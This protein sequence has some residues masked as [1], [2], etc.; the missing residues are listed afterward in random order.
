MHKFPVAERVLGF[1]EN[2]KKSK[3]F[4]VSRC[5]LGLCSC[6]FWT[7]SRLAPQGYLHPWA[8]P[9]LGFKIVRTHLSFPRCSPT[10]TLLLCSGVFVVIAMILPRLLLVP[11]FISNS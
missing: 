9:L 5:I 4:M 3:L 2:E 10:F 11:M 6:T 8:Q 1:R 7:C